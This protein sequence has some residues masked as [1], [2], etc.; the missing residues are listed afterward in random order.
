[1]SKHDP[2]KPSE[3]EAVW[4]SAAA[5]GASNVEPEIESPPNNLGNGEGGAGILAV[6][7]CTQQ[8][9]FIKN[10]CTSAA[11][12]PVA[13]DRLKLSSRWAGEAVP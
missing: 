11:A 6:A 5:D 13:I 4:C 3:P 9:V 1:M 7:N 10:P 2:T 8:F 12:S